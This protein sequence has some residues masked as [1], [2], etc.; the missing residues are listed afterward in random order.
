MFPS[1]K[2]TDDLDRS[3][4]HDKM[5]FSFFFFKVNSN[6]CLPFYA[7]RLLLKKKIRHRPFAV[8]TSARMKN[9]ASAIQWR[10]GFGLR[11][12]RPVFPQKKSRRA[13][14]KEKKK[15]KRK[16]KRRGEKNGSLK[17]LYAYINFNPIFI[18]FSSAK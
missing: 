17:R 8:Q 1:L 5:D 9:Q 11:R 18:F 10:G 4:E 16:E 13:K 15:K 2:E 12:A 14:R 3:N 7:V 6:E